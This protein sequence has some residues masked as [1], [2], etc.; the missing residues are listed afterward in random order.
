MA[1]DDELSRAFIL[2]YC[3]PVAIYNT[4]QERHDKSPLFLTRTLGYIRNSRRGASPAALSGRPYDPRAPEVDAQATR[5][6][7]PQKKGEA[8][9][10]PNRPR[11]GKDAPEGSL[12]YHFD[13]SFKPDAVPDVP[14]AF[15]GG[16]PKVC[17][18]MALQCS[19]KVVSA[20]DGSRE[21]A[22][23]TLY[24]VKQS[25]LVHVPLVSVEE[26]G[27]GTMPGKAPADKAPKPS[28]GSKP[29]RGTSASRPITI[30]LEDDSGNMAENSDDDNSDVHNQSARDGAAAHWSVGALAGPECSHLG[31]HKGGGFAAG[32]RT[33][34]A[35]GQ[36][37]VDRSKCSARVTHV[38]LPDAASGDEVVFL[39]WEEH[40]DLSWIHGTKA[41]GRGTRS[42]SCQGPSFIPSGSTV[43]YMHMSHGNLL[44]GE[45]RTMNS[46]MRKA[47]LVHDGYRGNMLKALKDQARREE[48]ISGTLEADQSKAADS[49][50]MTF[51]LEPLD[52][53]LLEL[54]RASG[55][56]WTSWRP[57]LKVKASASRP[58]NKPGQRE[59]VDRRAGEGDPAS[60]A[61]AVGPLSAPEASR[62]GY[63]EYHYLYKND[64][65]SKR[66]DTWN[67][68]CSFCLRRC[69]GFQGLLWHLCTNHSLFKFNHSAKTQSIHV[70]CRSDLYTPSGRFRDVEAEQ[71]SSPI[72]KE[73]AFERRVNGLRQPGFPDT[74][75]SGTSKD[76][77]LFS[78][79]RG[80][81]AKAKGGGKVG[82]KLKTKKKRKAA[83]GLEGAQVQSK[84]LA[85]KRKKPRE[86]E[87]EQR[88]GKAGKSEHHTHPA[89][90]H[91]KSKKSTLHSRTFFHSRSIQPMTMSEVLDDKDSDDDIDVGSQELEDRRYLDTYDDITA[92]EKALMLLWNSFVQENRIYA[93]SYVKLACQRFAQVNKA[94]IAKTAVRR[95]C[96]LLHL[97]NLADFGLV[98]ADTIS[99]CLRLVDAQAAAAT[100]TTTTTTAAE[101]AAAA[102]GAKLAA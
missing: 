46:Y 49:I 66:E 57:S 25:Q 90:A 98:D 61:D 37:R 10:R 18:V 63:V 33:A 19:K 32:G 81:G 26:G 62:T 88:G 31:R 73:F 60:N 79:R 89:G 64:S 2:Q 38:S 12:N 15:G 96:F 42:G 11:V 71:F 34:S 43:Y 41:C 84:A 47:T 3:Q 75:A 70:R 5:R 55:V 48:Y 28:A 54:N 51:A 14:S 40:P 99:G 101:G 74:D 36:H 20:G 45:Y 53:D 69:G 1:T 22:K 13:L 83:D 91:G 50:P 44:E 100:T 93:D 95:R 77:Q 97:M 27:S 102:P 92:E 4:L 39:V 67:F 82:N 7:A 85:K 59:P 16:G 30:D 35:T 68:S 76:G 9:A 56:D 6:S 8:H 24:V 23:M 86:T 65:L 52:G 78:K 17:S 72:N 58:V 21:P 80:K 29:P 94:W 87:A